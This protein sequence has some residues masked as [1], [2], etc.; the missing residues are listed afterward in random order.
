[1]QPRSGVIRTSFVVDTDDGLHREIIA[2]PCAAWSFRPHYHLGDEAV[3]ILRGRARLRL[4]RTSRIVAAGEAVVVPARTVHRFEPVD[5]QGWAF[6]SAFLPARPGTDGFVADDRETGLTTRAKALLRQRGSLHT[7]VGRIAAACAVSEQYLARRFRQ[8]TGTS[9]HSF[10]VLMALQDAKTLLKRGAAI[11]EAALD[12]GFY[13]QAH[14]TREFVRTFGL[15]PG[16]FRRAWLAAPR[17][18]A[19]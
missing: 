12:T 8:E 15:T 16:A 5:P 9:L 6:A 17:T 18:N 3:R 11:V 1:M 10:H 4:G 14:L 2:G 19:A 13:D 7:D